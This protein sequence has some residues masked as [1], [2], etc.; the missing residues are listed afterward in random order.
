MTKERLLEIHK[1][2]CGEALEIMVRKNQDYSG[3]DADPFANFRGSATYG[4]EPEIGIMIR[5]QDKFKR[6]QAFLKNGTLAVQDEG[7]RDTCN[8]II[9]Y[10]ILL[11]GMLYER[12]YHDVSSAGPAINIKVDTSGFLGSV[13]KI[14]SKLADNLGL[15]VSDVRAKAK[16]LIDKMVEGRMESIRL[17][18]DPEEGTWWPVNTSEAYNLK[19]CTRHKL[20]ELRHNLEQYTGPAMESR[21]KASL[22]AVEKELQR[23]DD[24]ANGK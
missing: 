22:V 8:D 23:R 11:Y 14:Q 21:F 17:E 3:G 20:T 12:S 15:S 6:L 10:T 1:E 18:V 2:L 4:V 13:D 5:I 24:Y 19:F 16:E 9:N 7:V